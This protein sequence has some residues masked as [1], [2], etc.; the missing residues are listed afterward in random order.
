MPKANQKPTS[1]RAK[2]RPRLQ[3]LTIPLEI[4]EHI[5]NDLLDIMPS[6]MFDLLLAN[7]QIARETKPFLYRQPLIFDGQAEFVAWLRKADRACLRHVV[8]IHFKLH[9]I[10]PEKIVGALGKRLRQAPG[11]GVSEDCNDNPYEEACDL[12]ITR[13]GNCFK[14]LP[15]VKRFTILPYS[16]SDARPPYDMLAAFAEMVGEQFPHLRSLTNYEELLPI[17]FLS[18][19]T[20]LSHLRFTGVSTSTRAEVIS[21]FRSLSEL[22]QLE[23]WRPDFNIEDQ[24]YEELSDIAGAGRCNVSDIL[25]CLPRLQAFTFREYALSTRPSTAFN[26]I[27]KTIFDLL[28]TLQKHPRLQELEILTNIDL[29]SRVQE[30]FEAFISSSRSLRHIESYYDDM[31]AF[32]DLAP[33]VETLVMRLDPASELTPALLTDILSGVAES[34]AKL[35]KLRKVLLYMDSF[36]NSERTRS[37]ASGVR[38]KLHRMGITLKL[39]LWD[40]PSR[41]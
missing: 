24:H 15:N 10:D 21:A 33:T 20:K 27:R 8:E 28:N 30:R 37:I 1:T 13:L 17:T 2:S 4:R 18:S 40:G 31:P 7:R 3:F 6:T 11:T 26:P 35:P 22:T 32:E 12:E 39:K 23:I 38:E 14:Y 19:F 9:D 34:R 16:R 29:L 41:F 36:P 5:Y 25:G